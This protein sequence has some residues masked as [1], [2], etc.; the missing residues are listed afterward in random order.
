MTF[1]TIFVKY[2]LL[3]EFECITEQFLVLTD[4]AEA[5]DLCLDKFIDNKH[6]RKCVRAEIFELKAKNQTTPVRPNS[7]VQ[8]S[9]LRTSTLI[10]CPVSRAIRNV[11]LNAK[12]SEGKQ[13]LYKTALAKQ[14]SDELNNDSDLVKEI[15]PTVSR[16]IEN[17]LVLMV[18]KGRFYQYSLTPQAET[19]IEHQLSNADEE[20]TDPNRTLSASENADSSANRALSLTALES[21]NSRTNGHSGQSVSENRNLN[22]S[23]DAVMDKSLTEEEDDDDFCEDGWYMYDANGG[24]NEQS[25]AEAAGEH[26]DDLINQP[27]RPKQSRRTHAFERMLKAKEEK[28]KSFCYPAFIDELPEL[29]NR[30]QGKAAKQF[31]N[32]VKDLILKQKIDSPTSTEYEGIAVSLMCKYKFFR[33]RFSTGC[34]SYFH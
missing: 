4:N 7:S 18:Q 3:K 21:V 9:I 27:V 2:D 33:E 15:W 29:E 23:E 12:Q 19:A 13:Y 8:R 26:G 32:I 24:E 31:R 10:N 1:E 16:L 22:E 20:N 25:C 30:P 28:R 6:L 34:V 17:Q 5:I 14:V 11:L